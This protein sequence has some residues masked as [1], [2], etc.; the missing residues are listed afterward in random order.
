MARHC[1]S[2]LVISDMSGRI[3]LFPI[4]YVHVGECLSIAVNHVLCVCVS[5]D[6]YN[7]VINRVV[8]TLFGG[9]HG[10]Q[11]AEHDSVLDLLRTVKV[12]W[13]GCMPLFDIIWF[14][15]FCHIRSVCTTVDSGIILFGI[16]I[17]MPDMTRHFR[18]C[19]VMSGN[20]RQVGHGWK[21]PIHDRPIRWMI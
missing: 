7:G 1:R 10:D 3:L 6:I 16:L 9:A 11:V 5:A 12:G 18:S 13:V 21:M 14:L 17:S 8:L 4:M 15:L 20:V 2:C 19:L